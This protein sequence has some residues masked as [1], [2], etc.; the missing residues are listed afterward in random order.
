MKIYVNAIPPEGLEM[1]ESL[2][3][4]SLNLDT[5]QVRF[6]QDLKVK[7]HL[8]KDKDILTINCNARSAKRQVC[9]RCLSEFDIPFE[10][11]MNFIYKLSGEYT[12]DLDDKIKDEIILDYPMKMLCKPDC[13]GLCPQC[14]KNLNE[15][16]CCCKSQTKVS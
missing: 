8:E 13:Q 4:S 9:S 3:P 5:E 11:N 10:K 1:E 7:A 15:G 12:I 16:P 2:E 14:G 6:T